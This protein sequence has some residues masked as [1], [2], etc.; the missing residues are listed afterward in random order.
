M[1]IPAALLALALTTAPAL[2]AASTFRPV[3]PIPLPLD[4]VS[5]W[6][7]HFA[8]RPL[9]IATVDVPG[10]GKQVVW[11]MVYQVHNTSDAPHAL[12]P[13]FELV[14][15][16]G[17]LRNLLDDPAPAVLEQIKKIEDPDGALNIQSSIAIAKVK[18][19]V[20]RANSVPNA[21][22]GVAVW[23]DAVGRV[24]ASNNFSV[25]VG[26]LSNGVATQQSPDGSEVVS[27]K[28]LQIDFVKPTDITSQRVDDIRPNDNNGVGSDKWIYRAVP[29]KR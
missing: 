27:R 3:E 2:G 6:T 15:K 1:R 28:T 26:G 25:Y 20:T 24:G 19:P 21:V 17:E 11:Y 5:V 4:R 14:T 18:I 9:R 29:V 16:D 22:Y 13:S 12:V 23:T 10:K 7:F 8:Y